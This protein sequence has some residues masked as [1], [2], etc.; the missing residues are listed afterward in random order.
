MHNNSSG[1]DD[2]SEDL[3]PVKL[4]YALSTP[5]RIFAEIDPKQACLVVCSTPLTRTHSWHRIPANAI[6]YYKRGSFPELRLLRTRHQ[7]LSMVS[8]M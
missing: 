5:G 6:L 7:T 3:E 4:K 2:E 8:D 1:E